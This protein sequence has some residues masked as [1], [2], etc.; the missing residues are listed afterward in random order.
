MALNDSTVVRLILEGL[1]KEFYRVCVGISGA[2]MILSF[3]LLIFAKL[4]N[5][6][7]LNRLSVLGQYTLGIY[8]IQTVLLER[9]IKS[10]ITFNASSFYYFNFLLAP[11]ISLA[12]LICC[13]IL[14]KIFL[15]SKLT[16]F[17]L[18]GK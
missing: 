4:P 2:V 13:I 10:M 7:F 6:E 1:L 9:I 15:H 18:L 8:V 12:V 5:V 3:I 14:V 11:A 17:I 16:S